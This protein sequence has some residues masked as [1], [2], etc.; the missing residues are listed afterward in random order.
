MRS[1]ERNSIFTE[2]ARNRVPSVSLCG[3][4][5]CALIKDRRFF[6]HIRAILSNCF[7]PSPISTRTKDIDCGTKRCSPSLVYSITLSRPSGGINRQAPEELWSCGALQVAEES[8]ECVITV[9]A[10]EVLT[11]TGKANKTCSLMFRR[12]IK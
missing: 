2:A 4:C 3:A 9:Q 1:Q 11:E 10:D 5:V 12:C 8:V 6:K 7:T